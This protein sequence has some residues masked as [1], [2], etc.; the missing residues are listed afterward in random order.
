MVF[1]YVDIGYVLEQ[2]NT[3]TGHRWNF[4]IEWQTPIPEAREIKQFIV[5][6][7]LTLY[8]NAEQVVS[9]VNYGKSDIAE[10]TSGGFL[11]FGNDM[12]AAVSDC[13][14]KCASMFGIALDVYSGGGQRRQDSLHPEAVI[15]EE[16]KERLKVLA[17]GANIGHSGLKKVMNELYDYKNIDDIQRQHFEAIK[18]RLDEM[19]IDVHVAE[20]PDGI[21]KGFDILDIPKAKRLAVYRSYEKQG[22]LDKLEEKIKEKL[23]ELKDKNKDFSTTK[24]T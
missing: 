14:K 8:G 5:R 9:K 20:I 6:G 3:L 23:K 19:D 18:N 1:D 11:D 4:E 17:E 15:T 12:K 21:Q 24:E 10:K 7:K 2:L 13:V 22:T 16:Q